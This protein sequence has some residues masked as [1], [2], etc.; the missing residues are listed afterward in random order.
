MTETSAPETLRL[1]PGK[2]LTRPD[3]GDRAILWYTKLDSLEGVLSGCA[4]IE[5]RADAARDKLGL[6]HLGTMEPIAAVEL[7]PETTDDREDRGRPTFVEAGVH[8]R[9]CCGDGPTPPAPWGMTVDLGALSDP[10]TASVTGL[11][12]RVC[13]RTPNG[14]ERVGS[15]TRLAVRFLGVPR[16]S[17]R[18]FDGDGDE[19][20]ARRL[21]D[22]EVRRGRYVPL[23]DR[24]VDLCNRCH[25]R[26]EENDDGDL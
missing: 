10:T 5:H 19:E 14:A 6:I 16:T 23:A 17:R 8:P 9:F 1:G 7:P 2:S 18:R 3:L 11:P 4:D 13:G 22:Q 25:E 15:E 20:F 26:Q 21:D 12:E 24:L